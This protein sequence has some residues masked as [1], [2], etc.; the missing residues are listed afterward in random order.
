M[1][2]KCVICG[3]PFSS[4][5]DALSHVCVAAAVPLH[6]Q[7]VP[8]TRWVPPTVLSWDSEA[9]ETSSTAQSQQLPVWQAQSQHCQFPA[10][11]DNSSTAGQ[12]WLGPA[13]KTAAQA[14]QGP[15][16]SERARQP[17][18]SAPVPP[19]PAREPNSSAAV[20]AIMTV[21]YAA[22][23]PPPAQLPNSSAGVDA[24]MD[25]FLNQ[26]GPH[27]R[28]LQQFASHKLTQQWQ[29]MTQIP[30]RSLNQRWSALGQCGVQVVE[31]MSLQSGADAI[32]A[33]AHLV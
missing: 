6:Q 19:P 22:Q 2:H 23:T 18:G 28:L 20:E 5:W 4:A 32:C 12:A 1:F 29:H 33:S 30:R 17:D 27:V 31:I 16:P 8:P 13:H 14:W 3:T 7:W 10:V 26:N 24:I 11:P 9:G 15:D 21:F 25:V